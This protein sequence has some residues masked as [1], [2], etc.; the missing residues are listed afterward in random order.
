MIG[1]LEG[2][3]Q[4]LKT[5]RVVVNAGGV[6]Y[7]V[8]IPLSTYYRLEGQTKASLHIHTHVREDAIALYGFV[9]V[10]EKTAFEKL[11]TI[12]GI[13]PR[14]A[15]VILS[16][17]GV[18]DLAAAIL[19]GDARR[20]N[21]IPGVGTKTS[22]RICLELRDKLILSTDTGATRPSP[23]SGLD[24]DVVSALVNLGYRN[25]AAAS[26]VSKARKTFE[27]EPEFSDLLRAALSQLT[28][29]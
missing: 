2:P 15:Q 19:Q 13:G 20:L 17:I 27:D 24:N 6:G 29:G 16:G 7:L 14:L 5:D 11:I 22:E 9:T 10:D 8:H 25:A 12:S 23:L 21:S 28:G 26:A 3:I 1:Y 18:G 4:S